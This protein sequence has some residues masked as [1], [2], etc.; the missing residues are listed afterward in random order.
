M[1]CISCIERRRKSEPCQLGKFHGARQAR[2]V[3]YLYPIT[4]RYYSPN[5][6]ANKGQ[7]FGAP[8]PR[9]T[10][11]NTV[12]RPFRIYCDGSEKELSSS[13][14]SSVEP[15]IEKK[16]KRGGKP[17]AFV[18]RLSCSS[19]AKKVE[20][21]VKSATTRPPTSPTKHQRS[22]QPTSHQKRRLLSPSSSKKKDGGHETPARKDCTK[23]EVDLADV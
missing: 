15:S 17:P 12:R 7:V 14:K 4:V 5:F 23:K 16:P 3:D 18:S 10:K 2:F 1:C 9:P 21:R 13:R 6:K 22:P 8:F 11:K 19:P 20:E